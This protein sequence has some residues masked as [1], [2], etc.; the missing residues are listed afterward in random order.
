MPVSPLYMC[1][2][3]S[4]S[5]LPYGLAHQAPLSLRFFRQGDWSGLLFTH[6]YRENPKPGKGN[7]M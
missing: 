2:V 5:L 7:I 3:V 6:E 1:S 4:P